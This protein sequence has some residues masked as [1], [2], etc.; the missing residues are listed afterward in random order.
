[1]AASCTYH[2]PTIISWLLNKSY[3]KGKIFEFSGGIK[4]GEWTI[5][6]NITRQKEQED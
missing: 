2:L 3:T 6:R 1:M 5:S 4:K